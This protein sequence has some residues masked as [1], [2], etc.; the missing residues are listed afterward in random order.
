GT[1]AGTADFFVDG[2][3]I[4]TGVTVTKGVAVLNTSTLAQ[5]IP[6]SATPHTITVNFNDTD[7]NFTNSS[8]TLT[9][10]LTVNQDGS[11]VGVTSSTNPSV[12]GTDVTFTI[13]VGAAS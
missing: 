11:T 3:P 6:V 1:P 2:S 10:G 4:A 13:T 8:G 9:G 12:Y 5:Q 7:G